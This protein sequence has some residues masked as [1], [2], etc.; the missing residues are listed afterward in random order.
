MPSAAVLDAMSK[1]VLSTPPVAVRTP[2]DP[3]FKADANLQTDLNAAVDAI[4]P[5]IRTETDEKK[6]K[7][8]FAVVD[9]TD[10]PLNPAYA[11][12]DDTK[13]M[14]IASLSKLL[15]LYAAYH[16][17]AVLRT[18]SAQLPAGTTPGDLA[19]A[20]RA[21]HGRSGVTTPMRPWIEKLFEVFAR[22]DVRFKIGKLLS[23]TPVPDFPDLDNVT[24]GHLARVDRTTGPRDPTKPK[25]CFTNDPTQFNCV[26][27]LKTDPSKLDFELAALAFREQLRSMAG[28]SD[29]TSAAVVI[30][31]LGFPYL[32]W[33]TRTSGLFQSAWTHL[34]PTDVNQPG[35][36]GLFVGKDFNFGAWTPR[37]LEAPQLPRRRGDPGDPSQAGTAR[38]V[39]ALMTMLAQDRLIDR[40]AC[41]E[42]REM[43]RNVK[44][45]SGFTLRDSQ[46]AIDNGTR[47]EVSP[48][49][50]GMGAAGWSATQRAWTFDSP[51]DGSTPGANPRDEFAVSKIGLLFGPPHVSNALFIR[52]N[53]TAAKTIAA[54]LVSIDNTSAAE[55]VPVKFGL[56]MAH[57]LDARH[58]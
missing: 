18:W 57:R 52:T 34:S 21:E 10:D 44:S 6:K 31:A 12:W 55:T 50:T 35:P 43:L 4:D 2:L 15:P 22:G 5:A 42:M 8:A 37:P 20:V 26:N 40:E 33:L 45:G 54:V 48:I 19:N 58:P 41:V 28:W 39:A 51:I 56:E 17:R 3:K 49:A 23:T 27:L 38:S 47:G 29:D 7:R 25:K 13:Q 1:L 11:G 14:F 24:K 53:R 16:L 36:S 32:W 9:L 30:E 46:G